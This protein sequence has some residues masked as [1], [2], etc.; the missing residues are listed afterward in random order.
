MAPMEIYRSDQSDYDDNGRHKV[1]PEFLFTQFIVECEERSHQR[2]NPYHANA[3]FG[4]ANVLRLIRSCFN[5]TDN[6]LFGM[7]GVDGNFDID[8]NLKIESYSSYQPVYGIG[9]GIDG[10]D[11]EPVFLI[12]DNS[13]NNNQ[14]ALKHVPDD[15]SDDIIDNLPALRTRV[16][17]LL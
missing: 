2:F 7:E 5:D 6:D 11:D 3:L 8:A 16:K 4:N 13:F 17:L 14:F 15:R 9:S 12:S 10:R 1:R